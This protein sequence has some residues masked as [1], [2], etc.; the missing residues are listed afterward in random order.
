MLTGPDLS[1]WQST[2]VA[3]PWIKS[4]AFGIVKASQGF[5]ITDD[6]HAAHVGNLRSL[7]KLVGHYH[8]AEPARNG[9]AAEADYFVKAASPQ[10]GEALILDFEP[11]NQN[12][13]VAAYPAWIITFAAE[14]KR[15]TGAPCWIYL[16][17]DWMGQ[18]LAHCT[19][20]QANLI[21][22]MP[23][24]KAEYYYSARPAAP[25]SIGGWAVWTCWQW[26]DRPLDQNVFNGDA[27]TWH[28]LGVPAKGKTPSTP[29]SPA[30]EADMPLTPADA[31]TIWQADIIPSPTRAATN[32]N[33]QPDSYLRQIYLQVQAGNA[34]IAA[35]TAAVK[36]LAS[37]QGADP[38]AIAGIVAY[39]VKA[40]LAEITVSDGGA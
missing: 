20:A 36:A 15:L 33:W 16:N 6:K 1:T 5:R 25:K 22:S 2:T 4:S 26:T 32:P 13:N 19:S 17:G 24:W 21:K 35:L 31:V 9:P 10:V 14:V 40:R 12:G 23:L 28:A 38:D 34:Q 39:A 3:A 30:Q 8:Y 27:S 7:G 18:V 11:Y 29:T 37:S